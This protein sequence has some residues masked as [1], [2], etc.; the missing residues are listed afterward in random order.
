MNIWSQSRS[1]TTTSAFSDHEWRFDACPD[2]QLHW[3]DIYEHARENKAVVEMVEQYRSSG[4]WLADGLS[5]DGTSNT[6]AKLFVDAFPEFPM[7]PFLSL[8]ADVRQERCRHLICLREALQVRVCVDTLPRAKSEDDVVVVIRRNAP[9]NKLMKL[10]GPHL[11]E[12]RGPQRPTE[13]VNYLAMLRLSE[14]FGSWNAVIDY[15]DGVGSSLA[16]VSETKFSKDK[17]KAVVNI[18]SVL[19]RI[20]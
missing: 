5:L 8:A 18:E 7:R 20:V 19:R 14:K 12:C 3:C 2:D 15:L 11:K 16:N 1:V 4:K 13:R 6:L 10:I 17:K 9:R